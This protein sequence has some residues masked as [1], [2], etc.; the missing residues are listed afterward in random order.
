MKIY[1]DTLQNNDSNQNQLTSQG[2]NDY[3]LVAPGAPI[4]Q[5]CIQMQYDVVGL[6]DVNEKGIYFVDVRGDPNWWA[7]VLTNAGVPHRHILSSLTKEVRKLAKEK[8]I[9]IVIN[10]DREGGPMVTQHWDCF[11]STHTAMIEL[12][13]PKDSVLILQGNKKIEHQYR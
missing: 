11:L 3:W 5:K 2:K 1:F 10:A 12:G 6:T 13:L 8:K 4:K 7:G 9:R